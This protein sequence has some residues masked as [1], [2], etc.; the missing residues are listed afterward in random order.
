MKI[1][2]Y[3]P[4]TPAALTDYLLGNS[5][6]G[7]TTK[8]FLLSD[9]VTLFLNNI[10]AAE[11]SFGFVSSGLVWSGDA[12]ASTRAASM[13]SGRIKVNA[14]FLSIAAV[15]S[16]VFAASSDTYVDILDNLDGTGTVI[17]TAALNNAAAPTLAANSIRIAIIITGATTIASV[18][19]VNQ[20]QENKILPIVSSIPYAVTDSIGNL[21]CPRDSN[22]KLLGFRRI[23]S[24]AS[25][26]TIAQVIGLTCP[27]I[28]PSDRKVKVSFYG[29][30]MFCNSLA[31]FI[32]S[33]WDGVVNS[34][35]QLAAAAVNSAGTSTSLSIPAS[36]EAIQTPSSTSKTYNIGLQATVGTATIEVDPTFPCFIKVELE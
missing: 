17:Y 6:T 29:R 24:A 35:T 23:T 31:V 13:T 10:P 5:S 22:R 19:S 25:A 2:A 1:S 34:G 36:A 12:Y 11:G 16:R 27:V 30:D 20:G 4:Q 33:I 32:A 15:T 9:L 14:T 8:K 28:V 21:I 18:A 3:S 7:P 26:S